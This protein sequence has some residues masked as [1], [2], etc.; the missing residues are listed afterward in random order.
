MD[1]IVCS[2]AV[3]PGLSPWHAT[4]GGCAYESAHLSDRINDSRAHLLID[5]HDRERALLALRMQNFRLILRRLDR[6]AP[7]H[8]RRLLDVGSAHGWFLE[9]ARGL[10][11]VVGV[12]P[13]AGLAEKSAARGLPVRQ[14][15][16]P[17]ALDNRECF[18]VIVFNDVIEHIPDIAGALQACQQRLTDDGLL[19]LNLPNS[20][21]FF[22]R[23][24]KLL[25]RAGWSGPF[26][27]MWQKDLPS[28]HVHYFNERNLTDL[29]ARHGFDKADSFKLL[30]LTTEG[31]WERLRFAARSPPAL[32]YLQYLAVLA[33]VP[34]LRWLP[35]D[36]GVCVFRKRGRA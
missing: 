35:S 18:D 5:E 27:R 8:A 24:A 17:Q 21:G 14:G 23:L 15:Y 31:L 6:L 22:Y 20:R 9:V 30:T 28:P 1:C 29:V 26:E 16:F 11:D 12:E 33:I 32:L 4:C 25:A 36:I 19:V 13:D 7:P 3:R 2:R 10:F 34:M